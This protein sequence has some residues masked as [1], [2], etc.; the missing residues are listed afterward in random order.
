M[1]TILYQPNLHVS[2]YMDGDKSEFMKVVIEGEHVGRECAGC[3]DDF[4]VDEEAYIQIAKTLPPPGVTPSLPL[5]WCTDCVEVVTLAE[6]MAHRKQVPEGNGV[7]L[8]RG[9]ALTVSI[10]E[11]ETGQCPRC[12]DKCGDVYVLH[13]AEDDGDEEHEAGERICAFCLMDRFVD[14]DYIIMDRYPDQ[15]KQ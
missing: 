9:P 4:A 15:E 7:V 1:K 2:T 13:P 12:K 10:F 3:F 14:Y 6:L 8:H 5:L 11:N